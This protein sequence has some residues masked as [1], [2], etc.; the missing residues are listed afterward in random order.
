MDATASQTVTLSTAGGL[1]GGTLH[2]WSTDLSAPAAYSP[3][4]VQGTDLTASGGTYTLTLAPGHIYTVTTTTGQGAGSTTPPQRSQLSL[5]YSDTFAGYTAG[6]EA[7]YFA[8][9]N[10]A[11]ESA[12]CGGGRSGQCLRQM[13][14][15]VPIQWTHETSRQPYTLMGE[16]GWSNYTVSSDV[17]LEKSG[18][19]A[20][21]IG[22]AGTQAIN[23]GGLNA[24]HLRL[25]DT[26]AW[27]LQKTNTAWTWTTLASGTVTAPG[28]GTWH[29]LSLGF[30]GTTITVRIDGT[31][32]GT[33]TDS[34]YQGG[35]IGLGT[36]DYSPVQYSNLSITPGTVPDL[37]GKYE[38]VSVRSGK[39]LDAW[40][41]GTANGTLI[42]QW[43]Y[44]G[45]TNQQWTLARNSA[46]YYT[47]TG[48]GSGK[49]LDIPA[50]TNWSGIQLQLW[51]G[52]GQ[53]NQ[54]WQIAPTD[55]GNYTIESRL[56]GYM[57]DVFG[58]STTNGAAIDQWPNSG[59]TN[60]QWQ[61]VKIS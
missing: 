46:G 9:M 3:R 27:S 21:I 60:Q 56:N 23:N 35:Q 44:S 32:V 36:A 30:Q 6:A 28:T 10:G 16:L 59:G 1:P 15:S 53:P 26:G 40:Q 29:N 14:Q 52:T 17:L 58:N 48:V 50:A 31:T 42:D 39:A 45:A 20:E 57:V 61:L 34:S 12:P 37:S 7:K 25:S 51:S 33:V 22:R 18:S 24:Y 55:G 4:M 13:A 11:F 49:A 19:A 5:P 2:V 41:V 43:A 47:I 54:Q 8:S 38:I